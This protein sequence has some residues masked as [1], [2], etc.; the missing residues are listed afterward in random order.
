MLR[1]SCYLGAANYS[2]SSS[3]GKP[4]VVWG[5]RTAAC[6]QATA[7]LVLYFDLRKHDCQV[8]VSGKSQHLAKYAS[9][10]EM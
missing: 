1:N 5:L 3:Y 7:S 6:P 10:D 4:S 9:V 8:F 2:V